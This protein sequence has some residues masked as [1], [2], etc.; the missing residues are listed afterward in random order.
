MLNNIFKKKYKRKRICKARVYIAITSVLLIA[1]L[2]S[3]ITPYFGTQTY[4][5]NSAELSVYQSL[6][7]NIRVAIVSYEYSSVTGL[8]RCDFELSDG[9]GAAYLAN[10]EYHINAKYA[11]NTD[12][13]ETSLCRV[14][15]T[16]LVAYIRGLPEG[17]KLMAI[18]IK[19]NLI[20]PELESTDYLSGR[21]LTLYVYENDVPV[22]VELSVSTENEMMADYVTYQQELLRAEVKGHEN[23]INIKFLAISQTREL[24]TALEDDMMFQTE[25]EI[26]TSNRQIVAYNTQIENYKREIEMLNDSIAQL[27]DKIVLLDAKKAQL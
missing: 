5:Y 21:E 9:S 1:L 26:E 23:T 2:A 27:E 11:G 8:M 18:N 4:G 7:N 13:L 24:I 17:F 22:K 15:D 16:Y 10:T 14:S 6:G 12:L 20:Y 19:G 3:F 25:D